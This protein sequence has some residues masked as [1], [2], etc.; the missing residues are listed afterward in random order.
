MNDLLKAPYRVRHSRPA[1]H[2]EIISVVPAWWGGR[3]LT[4]LLPR[5]YFVHFCNTSFVIEKDG[6]IAGFLIGFLSPANAD[7]GY[8]HCCGV[9]P[10]DRSCGLGHYLYGRFFNLCETHRRTVVKACT[11]PVNKGSIAFHAR[12]GFEI[13]AGDIDVDGV[14]AHR[15]YNRPGDAKV[16]F[17][18][19]L[20][21]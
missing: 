2:S 4:G 18:K 3:D 7:E 10:E 19:N 21:L 6:G 14:A 12:L 9:K 13:E 5:L 16:L 1:D 8:I 20:P 15:D 11:S 17:K